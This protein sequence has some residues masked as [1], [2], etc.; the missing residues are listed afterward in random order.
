MKIYLTSLGFVFPP[1]Y[2]ILLCSV[3]FVAC[4]EQTVRKQGYD[5]HGI[6]IS[7]H[8]KEIDWEKVVAQGIQFAFIKATEGESYKDSFFCENWSEMKAVGIKRGAYHFF[9][10]TVSAAKQAKNFIETAEL[11]N[12]DFAPVLDVEVMDGVAPETLVDNVKAWL[13]IVENHFKVRPIIYSNQKFFNQYLAEHINGYP[14]WVARYTSWRKPRLRNG[15]DWQFWQYG[16]RGKLEGIKGLVDF[17]VFR[18]SK[19][20]M[21]AYTLVRPGPLLDPPPAPTSDLAV[22]NP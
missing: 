21:E 12:G 14:L 6:D 3:L 7:H 18:G 16:N 4:N 2:G 22:T 20:D 1:L 17:N 10:P 19:E 5:V 15:E 9:R 11:E 8:Q 13:Q